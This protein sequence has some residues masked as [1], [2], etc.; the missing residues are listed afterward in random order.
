MEP[1]EHKIY[2]MDLKIIESLDGTSRLL[3]NY[4]WDLK[5]LI[6]SLLLI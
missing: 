5:M 2:K 4:F 1:P 6:S 3:K